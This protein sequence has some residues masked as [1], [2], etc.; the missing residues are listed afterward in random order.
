M[1]SMVTDASE[2]FT[3]GFTPYYVVW[4]DAKILE[5]YFFYE[6]KDNELK[7]SV[8]YGD[9]A[10]SKNKGTF[11]LG[12]AF[13]CVAL[14]AAEDFGGKDINEDGCHVLLNYINDDGH[15]VLFIVFVAFQAVLYCL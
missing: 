12:N 14:G 11:D 5:Q 8:Y 1:Y 10:T 3:N 4:R 15:V 7:S 9:N 13:T 6:Y 2:D